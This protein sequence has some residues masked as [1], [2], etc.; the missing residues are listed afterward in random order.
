M[1][2]RAFNQVFTIIYWL[3]A[4]KPINNGHESSRNIEFCQKIIPKIHNSS[5]CN[6]HKIYFSI[7]MWNYESLCY[8]Y[9][10]VIGWQMPIHNEFSFFILLIIIFATFYEKMTSRNCLFCLYCRHQIVATIIVSILK[11]SHDNCRDN[12]MSS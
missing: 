7:H 12:L 5:K 2:L 11:L 8:W 3:K 1:D 10:S 6:S 4:P 9:L